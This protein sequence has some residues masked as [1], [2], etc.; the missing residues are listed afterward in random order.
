MELQQSTA[1]LRGELF[2]VQR[3]Q[4][5][6]DVSEPRGNARVHHGA[7]EGERM[8]LRCEYPSCPKSV[9]LQRTRRGL[10]RRFCSD[11]CRV[12]AWS[13]KHPRLGVQ[14]RLEFGPT[15]SAQENGRLGRRERILARLRHGSATTREMMMLG[16]AGFSSRIRELRVAGH[17]IAVEMNEDGAV[18]R[19]VREPS[20]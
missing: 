18:Y 13:L 10:E 2:G 8:G 14:P 6:Q 16:G 1:E 11:I 20:A 7:A 15:A 12:R 4:E 3:D 9:P 5:Q 17:E 19:L